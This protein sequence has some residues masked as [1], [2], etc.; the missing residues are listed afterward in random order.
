MQITLFKV[1]ELLGYLL[2][3]GAVGVGGGFFL[4][5][6]RR[7]LLL[8]MEEPAADRL[9]VPSHPV[10]EAELEAFLAREIDGARAKLEL[11][12]GE[13]ID[14]LH[15]HLKAAMRQLNALP[16]SDP[17]WK[18]TPQPQ[19]QDSARLF[20]WP[21]LVILSDW[22]RRR[23]ADGTATPDDEWALAALDVTRR[24]NDFGR[25]FWARLVAADPRNL[26][27]MIEAAR[28]V[29]DA[30]GV[31][32]AATLREALLGLEPTLGG[33]RAKLAQFADDADPGMSAAARY[34]IE[35]LDPL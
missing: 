11:A 21:S 20:L 27:R 32:T 18:E 6:L 31:G 19:P 33:V 7:R 24:D 13:L 12:G 4:T 17:Y 28:F 9:Q 5:W 29:Q 1:L 35:V 15:G 22:L 14:L 3:M 30:S 34:A 2:L 16:E 8:W 26:R 23:H 10:P 25:E